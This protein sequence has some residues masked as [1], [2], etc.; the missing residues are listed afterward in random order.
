MRSTFTLTLLLGVVGQC[1][2]FSVNTPA[3]P[4]SAAA[5]AA[6]RRTDA[7]PRCVSVPVERMVP[8]YDQVLVDLQIVPSKTVA[9]VLLPTAFTDEETFD[10]FVKPEPRVGTVVAVGP[11]AVAN[12]GTRGWMPPI[13]VGSKVV[14]APT[15]GQRLQQEGKALRE[16][17]VF[18]FEVGDLWGTCEEA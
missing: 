7:A 11:G 2:C 18:L 6:H 14:V 16:S 17:T 1:A 3:Y 13:A 5:S 10:Q 9:G 15:A 4:Q 8:M 12:D